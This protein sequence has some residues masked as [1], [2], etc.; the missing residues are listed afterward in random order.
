MIILKHPD[1]VEKL[2]RANQIVAHLLE[3]LKEKIEPGVT[4]EELDRIAEEY[5]VSR[6]ARPAFKGYRGYPATLCTSIND[7]VVHGIP[8]REELKEGDLVSLD[9]GVV[10][11]GYYGDAAKTFPVMKV[12]KEADRLIRVTEESLYRGIGKASEGNRL[13]DISHEIQQYVEGHSFSVVR[14]FVGH[15]IGR[16]LHEEPQIP[17]FGQPNRGP[18]LKKGMVLAIEPMVNM[19]DWEVKIL[20]DTWTAVTADGSLSAHFEHT[21]AILDHETRILS[22][23]A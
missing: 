19:G 21:I 15:G 18:R 23:A 5:I 4:T 20:S 1:E 3:M 16:S 10:L 22:R 6:K 8:S 14:A 7:R 9:V 13:F 12:S 2:Y 17:N 11:D